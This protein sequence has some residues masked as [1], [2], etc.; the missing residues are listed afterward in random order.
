MYNV[1]VFELGNEQYNPFF[2]EQVVAMEARSKAVGSPPLRYM[3]PDNNGLNAGDA[4]RLLAALPDVVPRI[5]PDLH[6][7]AGG[8]VDAARGLFSNPPV[9]GFNQ[10]AINCETNAGT[11]DLKR[12]V[13]E[14]A[15][16]ID[17]FSADTAT[18]DRIYARTAS[19]CTGSSN[20]FDQWDQG[21][22][23]FLP[24]MTWLQPPGHTHVMIKD[25]WA[26][27]SLASSFDGPAFPFVAQRT[28]DGRTLV[29]RAA[30]VGDGNQPFSVTLGGGAAAK[31]PSMQVWTLGGAGF[32]ATDDN[33]P[34]N[35]DFIS[36]VSSMLPISPGSKFFNGT[37]PPNVF[38]VY[39]IALQ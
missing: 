4:A 18:T 26:E 2:V 9:P 13:Q 39:V 34:S 37:L 19:F 7:G 36:P 10:G 29:L 23:F 33:T 16:L 20:N 27:V 38:I 17:F 12:A 21:I 15:D 30:N 3:F 32:S 25:T 14:A 5:L 11:H 31:G 6:V 24:N 8:A 1:T 22:S 35:A 28:Q